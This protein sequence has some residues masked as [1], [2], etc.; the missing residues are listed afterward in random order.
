MNKLVPR[1]KEDW[2]RK[3]KEMR[4]RNGGQSLYHRATTQTR[5]TNGCQKSPTSTSLHLQ[6]TKTKTKRDT[7]TAFMAFLIAPRKYG[8]VLTKDGQ[9]IDVDDC[10]TTTGK[11]FT[12]TLPEDLPV[13]VQLITRPYWTQH[14]FA[15]QR[16]QLRKGYR[17]KDRSK[18]MMKLIRQIQRYL[19]A[20][21]LCWPLPRDAFKRATDARAAWLACSAAFCVA[22]SESIG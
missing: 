8:R 12:V 16:Q 15:Y 4:R 20:Q 17:K 3:K 7:S 6:T 10:S 18:V 21:A 13:A 5:L 2:W 19:Q 9:I 22:I 1:Q 14:L 11:Q